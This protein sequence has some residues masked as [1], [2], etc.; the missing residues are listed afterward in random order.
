MDRH[1]TYEELKTMIHSPQPIRDEV[2]EHIAVCEKCMEK[3]IAISQEVPV[4][5]A[6]NS[7]INIMENLTIRKYRMKEMMFNARVVFGVMAAI[8]MLFRTPLPNPQAQ[9][10]IIT[11]NRQQMIQIE[12]KKEKF[13]E[14]IQEN[15]NTFFEN[16]TKGPT[17]ND[18]TEE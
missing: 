18:K 7:A 10:D 5:P 13:S 1:Y 14:E 15:F 2:L 12:E 4:T 17:D 3:F 9:T 16:F 8:I 6:R 11:R